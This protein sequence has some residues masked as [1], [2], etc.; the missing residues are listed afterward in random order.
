MFYL[1]QGGSILQAL[2][3]YWLQSVVIGVVNVFRLLSQS[4][5]ITVQAINNDPVSAE[6]AVKYRPAMRKFFA[7]FF[8][9]HYG[10][11]HL[12][13]SFFLLAFTMGWPV[14]LNGVETVVELGS[15]NFVAILIVG[16]G[17]ALHHWLTYAEEQH[18]FRLNPQANTNNGS[19]MFRPYARILP[20][21]LIIIMGPVISVKYGYDEAFIFFMLLKTAADVVLFYTAAGH[22]KLHQ[23]HGNTHHHE[24]VVINPSK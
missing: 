7:F 19:T 17:F 6:D 20:M 21:H 2:W 4:T 11:F 15:A 16:L 24:P 18:Q 8:T 14:T 13:Y 12:I 9:F 22:P 1:F 5:V 10:G 3:I 23:G